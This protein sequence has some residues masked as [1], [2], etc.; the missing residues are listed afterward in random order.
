MVASSGSLEE[1]VRFSKRIEPPSFPLDSEAT[2]GI[3]AV[4]DRA[5]SVATIS[6]LA[7]RPMRQVLQYFELNL[8]TDPATVDLIHLLQYS[9]HGLCLRHQNIHIKVLVRTTPSDSEH[10]R[11]PTDEHGR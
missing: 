7:H 1:K 11:V 4:Q 3:V 9:I 10:H 8:T 6:K 2:A 5:N